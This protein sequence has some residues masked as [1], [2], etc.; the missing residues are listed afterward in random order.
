MHVLL[1]SLPS[2]LQQATTRLC[3]R[4]L[5]THRQFWVSLLWGQLLL[6]PGSWCTKGSVYALKSLFPSPVKF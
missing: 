6:S 3:W 1:H 4:L 5:D 2:T